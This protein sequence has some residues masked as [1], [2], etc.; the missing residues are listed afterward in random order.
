MRTTSGFGEVEPTPFG[1]DL[2]GGALLALGVTIV[3]AAALSP[4][5]VAARLLLVATA[6]AVYAMWTAD[7]AA[8]L[9]TAL[10]AYLLYAGFL[11]NR[12]GTLTWDGTSSAQQM[13]VLALAGGL[14][15]LGRWLRTARAAHAQAE[16][17]RR[18]LAGDDPRDGDGNGDTH[19]GTS[20]GG[21]R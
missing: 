7:L 6:V 19:P 16:E 10:L 4:N 5:E 14:A 9:A 11:I 13:L 2:A 8:S 21:A 12:F 18:L 3:S 1:I 17:F 15:G 20:G